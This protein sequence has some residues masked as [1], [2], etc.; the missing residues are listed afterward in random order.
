MAEALVEIH[1]PLL[2]AGGLSDDDYQFPWIEDI[3][4]FLVDLEERGEVEVYDDGEEW[5]GVYIFF[6]SGADVAALLAVASRVGKLQRVPRG[7]FAVVTDVDA[8]GYGQGRRV[9]LAS[10]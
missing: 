7:A 3:E 4:D 10:F 1:V 2:A 6:I 5:E 9:A 8:D